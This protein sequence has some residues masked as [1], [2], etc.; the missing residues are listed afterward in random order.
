MA[1]ADDGRRLFF[2]GVGKKI[3]TGS[4]KNCSP[5]HFNSALKNGLKINKNNIMW[6]IV[7]KSGI[8]FVK[9][10]MMCWNGVLEVNRE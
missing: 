1:P 8:E 3:P 10:K 2:M 5:S 6:G 4:R 9:K 7:L